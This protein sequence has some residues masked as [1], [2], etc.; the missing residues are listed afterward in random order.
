MPLTEALNPKCDVQLLIMLFSS[1]GCFAKLGVELAGQ[2][3]FIVEIVGTT[4]FGALLGRHM[5]FAPTLSWRRMS[6]DVSDL[7]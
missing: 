5:F 4:F 1:I 7:C 6:A 2:T 3:G